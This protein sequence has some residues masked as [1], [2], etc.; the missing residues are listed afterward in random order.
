MK[1]A[2]RR[3]HFAGSAGPES[4]EGKLTYVHNLIGALVNALAK[5]GASFV[6]P[7]G[8][9]PFLKGRTDGPSIIFDWTVATSVHDALKNGWVRPYGPNGHL[10]ETCSITK[11]DAHI[12]V[13]RRGIYDDLRS[14]N[15]IEMLM[16][17]PGWSAG[18]LRRQKYGQLGDVLIAVSGGQGVEQ[19]AIE[20][21]SKGKP[22]I[23]LD[24]NVGCSLGDGTGGAARLFDK[25]LANPDDFLKVVS[26]HSATNLLDLTKTRN[27]ETEINRVVTAVMNLLHALLPPRAFYVRLLCEKAPEYLS[28]ERFFRTTVDPLVTELGYE[29]LQMGLGRN[30]FAWM[31]QA[32]FDSLHH[33]SVAVV[34][35]TAL[36]PNCFMELGYA[37]GNKQRVIVTAREDTKISFDAFALETFLW[38]EGEDS[39]TCL[40]RMRTHW[41]RNIN[42]PKLVHPKQAK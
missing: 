13:T 38:K 30:E 29:P 28:V 19:L 6:V 24:I 20:Y 11:T 18:A 10:I 8:K 25:A 35:L 37:L 17:D 14:A 15:A 9:E 39:A 41:E 34:D 32:V 16:L 31:N 42:M 21:S 40:N 23:P 33:S 1:L 7:F 2:G 5:E 26:G 4:V 27:G 12:P 36:R 3:I 22:V